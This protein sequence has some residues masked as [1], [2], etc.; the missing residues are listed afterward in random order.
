MK[1]CIALL[2]FCA[3]SIPAFSAPQ[4]YNS[5]NDFLAVCSAVDKDTNLTDAEMIKN[6]QCLAYIQGLIDGAT[7]ETAWIWMEGKKTVHPI[8]FCR[9][10]GVGNLQLLRIALKFVRD[11]PENA[12]LETSALIFRS[13]ERAFPCSK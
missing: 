9:P 1:S 13:L 12:H 2:A 11:N 3:L 6:L 5:G 4:L 10:E 8:P 7:Y